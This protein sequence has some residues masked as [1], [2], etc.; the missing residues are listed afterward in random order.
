LDHKNHD[1]VFFSTFAAVLG[2]LFAIFFVCIV[3]ARWV[4]PAHEPDAAALARLEERIKPVGQPITDPAALLKVSAAKAPRAPLNGEQ[5]T[6]KICAACHNA[7]VLGAPKTGD[8]AAWTARSKAAGG[9]SGLSASVIK[10]KN[11]MPP[12]G[13]DPDLTDAE[14]KAAVEQ[15]LKQAGV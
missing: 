7:G 8:K 12:R 2:V 14:I 9:V 3:A 11:S 13:G 1:K 5:V 15:M 6:A 10:G 4:T